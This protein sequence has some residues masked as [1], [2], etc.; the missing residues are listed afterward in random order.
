MHVARLIILSVLILAIIVPY[1]PAVSDE[2]SRFW[3]HIRPGVIV[4]MDDIYASLR[5]F[6]AGSSSQDGIEDNAP[7]VDFD[8]VITRARGGF[9]IN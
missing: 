4:L 6:V 3:H 8:K 7:G 9:R 5:N 2:A 1:S